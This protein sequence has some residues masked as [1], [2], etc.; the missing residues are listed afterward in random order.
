MV[1]ISP[2][3]VNTW[4]QGINPLTV[5]CQVTRNLPGTFI[6]QMETGIDF[7][8]RTRRTDSLLNKHWIPGF[9]LII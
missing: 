9:S 1:L 7:A 6:F 2:S 8:W 5:L 3:Q 4:S